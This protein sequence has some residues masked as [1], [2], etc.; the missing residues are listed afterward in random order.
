MSK[1]AAKNEQ[2]N[3]VSRRKFL[4]L[5]GAALAAGSLTMCAGKSPVAEP[6]A[7]APVSG[8][9]VK[10]HHRLGR[11]GFEVSDVSMGCGQIS[12]S[13]VVRYAYDKGINYFDTAES[14]GN[15]ASE[16]KIGEAMQH[17][18]RKKIFI[19][20][21]LQIKEEDTET[22]ILDRF[23]KCRERL[24]TDYVDAL[25]IHSCAAA[26]LIG[27][28]HFHAAADRLIADGQLRYRGISNHGPRGDEGDSME[29]VLV[30]AAE[31][32]R[33]DLMLLSYNFLNK[34]EAENV[35]AACKRN[36]VGTTAMKT[37]PGMLEV[38]HFDPDNPSEDFASFIDGF[39]EGGGTREEAIE[40]IQGWLARQAEGI[41]KVKP[42]AEKYGI[43]T[44]DQL[45]ATAVQWVL[46]NPDMQTVT[47]STPDY[48]RVD[49]ALSVSGK[50]LTAQNVAFLRDCEKVLGDQYCRHGCNACVASCVHRL[51]V[52]TIMR[53]AYY[54]KCQG[55]EK[56]GMVKYAGL[57]ESN[58]ALCQTCSAPCRG[59]CP[60]GLDVQ[61]QLLRAHSL[62]TLA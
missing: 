21:K 13:N 31:D 22:S 15:G 62:L 45:T 51:P 26:D 57:K 7:E 24:Q 30:A 43:T 6:A 41:E 53:Y 47:V 25:Y 36:D 58:A 14:Y 50:P 9:L 3:R 61:G 28:P 39:V 55:R 5:G 19:T 37:Q 49:L 16:T 40:R 12:E 59:A 2:E 29:K 46:Q 38:P 23:G 56:H 52:N 10:K 32:G 11:T 42:F 20:T 18:D 8:S 44:E 27:N 1:K 34:E 60:H 35:L 54:A 4:E 33:F 17:M 48:E